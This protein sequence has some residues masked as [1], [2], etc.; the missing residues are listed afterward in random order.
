MKPYFPKTKK[1]ASEKWAI[2][3]VTFSIIASIVGLLPIFAILLGGLYVLVGVVIIVLTLGLILFNEKFANSFTS[4]A[5]GFAGFGAL[6]R[7][8]PY[9]FGIA[10][11]FALIAT[12]IFIKCQRESRKSKITLGIILTIIPIIIIFII[13]YYNISYM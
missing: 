9:A 2:F 13:K 10:S 7:Y 12:L 11:F 8:S 3:F 6:I 5:E 4:G 1:S